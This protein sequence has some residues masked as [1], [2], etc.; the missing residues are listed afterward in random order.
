[1]FPFVIRGKKR[2][3]GW[4]ALAACL[5]HTGSKHL[6]SLSI[7]IGQTF[8]FCP[9]FFSV[10]GRCLHDIDLTDSTCCRLGLAQLRLRSP[11]ERSNSASPESIKRGSH[12]RRFRV[13]MSREQD[14]SLQRSA[15]RLKLKFWTCRKTDWSVRIS[16][17]PSIRILRVV[18][19]GADGCL[20]SSCVA[21]L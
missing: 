9:L 2:E 18:K 8:H 20:R 7:S 17:I 1:M 16:G 14:Q 12:P 11:Q 3:F 5:A 4:C 15:G 13:N 10:K 21:S 19:G 6:H